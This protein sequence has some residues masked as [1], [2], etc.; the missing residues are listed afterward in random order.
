MARASRYRRVTTPTVLQME[1]MECGA[2]A[3]GIVLGYYGRYV[4]LEELRAAAG[5]SRD[6]AKL[7][8]VR[9]AAEGYGLEVKALKATA[10]QALAL[11]PPFIV[12]W[13][14]NHFL[15]VEGAA[16]G[17][18][19]VNDPAAGRRSLSEREFSE[20][21]SEVVLTL[22]PG[23]TF[24]RGGH[25]S[26]VMPALISWTR[27]SRRALVLIASISFLLVVPTI[28]LPAFLKVFVDDVLVRR[29]DEWLFP[30][31][32]GL[33]IAGALNGALVW[34]Q[35][36]VLL[37]LQTKFSITITT[38]FLWHMLQLPIMF[39]TQRF[40]GDI[41]SRVGSANYVSGLLSGPMPLLLVNAAAALIYA[42]VLWLFSPELTVIALVLTALNLIAVT[43]VQR[44][45]RDLTASLLNVSAKVSGAAMSGLQS[46]ETI[47]AAGT[48]GDFFRIWSGYQTNSI[49]TSQ[50]LHRTSVLLSAVPSFLSAVTTAAILSVGALLIIQ[51]SL[52]IGGLVAF[53]M[54]LSHFVSPIS[55]LIS[56]NTKL[57]QAS[58]HVSRLD[59]V[60]ATP[61][62]PIL[63]DQAESN[64]AAEAERAGKGFLRKRLSRNAPPAETPVALP[65]EGLLTG[66]IELR[67]V[68]FAFTALDPPFIRNIN[69]TIEPGERVA[70]VGPSGSGKSTLLRL[71]LGLYQ[72]T[73]G[74]VLYDGLP[75]RQ[76]GREAMVSSVG[77]VD[78]DTILFAG[79]VFENLTLWDP[80]TPWQVVVRAAQ[81]AMIHD[82]IATR[83]GGYESVV[84]EAGRNFSGGER[85]RLEI[86]RA[87]AR[88]PSILVLDE[89]TSALDTY[90]EAAIG[91]NVQ[92]RGVT[93]INV[94][95][96]LATIRDCEAI[97]VVDNGEIVESGGHRSLVHKRGLYAELVGA[98]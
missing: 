66:R 36:R 29:L 97:Y 60:L 78:Q 85:Q 51:G 5:V 32:L 14:E 43:L 76:I 70:L 80:Y 90:T 49:S 91:Q 1:A 22:S 10:E 33:V 39:F 9:T 86:A 68:S 37:R 2:A 71:I 50:R 81:D 7:S 88:E 6:G 59:D 44:R 52:S 31:L 27:G 18:V 93:S 16:R 87:L 69:L 3:L 40:G 30:L 58:G 89:A 53:K 79:T 42:A 61:I 45:I 25:R 34:F 95:H 62:D 56:F 47:K 67:D 73:S 65:H 20:A 11:K 83:P 98:Q 64:A 55:E 74:E 84:V 82:T 13:D 4:P 63:S 94:A 26:H 19:Y 54:L 8:H 12:F 77:W 21:F 48:E 46:I 17:R 23:K 57:Q 41:V 24:R 75:L 92:R 35:Q 38:G 28:L 72:P 96:R 15:V